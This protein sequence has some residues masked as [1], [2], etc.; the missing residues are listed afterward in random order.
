MNQGF[1]E[2][3]NHK[4]RCINESMTQK[5]KHES[6]NQRPAAILHDKNSAV[7]KNCSLGLWATVTMHLAT[8]AAFPHGKR[9][10]ASLMFSCTQPC[11]CVLPQTVANPRR[12]TNKSTNIHAASTVRTCSRDSDPLAFFCEAKL[13]LQ[14]YSNIFR[15]CCRHLSFPTQSCT[16]D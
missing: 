13:S 9:V 12:R 14:S 6:L 11:Q 3:T 4:N 1:N 10:A 8:S 16:P 15:K 2:S 5:K 7:I